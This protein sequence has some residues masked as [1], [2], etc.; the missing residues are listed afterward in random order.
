VGALNIF[1]LWV[2]NRLQWFFDAQEI[3]TVQQV[4]EASRHHGSLLQYLQQEVS[5]ATL[6]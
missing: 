2:E 4:W 5:E 6:S 3:K 1:A